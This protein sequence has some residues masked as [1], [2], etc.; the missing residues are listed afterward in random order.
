MSKII[1]DLGSW[2]TFKLSSLDET[3]PEPTPEIREKWVKEQE[4]IRKRVQIPD[5]DDDDRLDVQRIAGVDI[6]FVKG[7]AVDACVAVVVLEYPSLRAVYEGYEMVKLREPYISG[8]LAFR[9]APFFVQVI[10]R[11]PPECAPQL[12]VVDGNGV[13]HPRGCGSATHLGVLLG[14]PTVGVAKKFLAVDGLERGAVEEAF[15]R[16][17]GATPGSHM[18]LRGRTSGAVLG[19]AVRP[20]SSR[21]PLYVSPGHM[22]SLRQSIEVV[23]GCCVYRIPEP[24]RQADLRSRT[25]I[26]DHFYYN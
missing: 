17:C 5:D 16:E 6:S 21:V 4:E 1:T 15:A 19:A 3:L 13:L 11:I 22:I 9:E 23:L 14:L 26:K 18:L 24:T 25:F 10:R 7:S 12:V 2:E 20:R 8:F